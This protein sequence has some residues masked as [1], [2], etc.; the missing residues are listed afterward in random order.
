MVTYVL[1]KH[2]WDNCRPGR[3]L[4]TLHYLYVFNGILGALVDVLRLDSVHLLWVDLETSGDVLLRSV[5][6]IKLVRN[7]IHRQVFRV[8]LKPDKFQSIQNFSSLVR[9]YQVVELRSN[10]N[11]NLIA[12]VFGTLGDRFDSGHRHFPI[13]GI[14]LHIICRKICEQE[15]S[16][17]PHHPSIDLLN[18]AREYN[19]LS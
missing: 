3:W 13:D 12:A 4:F 7:P 11:D 8:G 10:M 1:Q 16:F 18:D 14:A 5:I 19:L 2:R 15:N 6:I 17:L 9:L